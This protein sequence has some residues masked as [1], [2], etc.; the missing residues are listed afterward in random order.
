MIPTDLKSDPDVDK[1][2]TAVKKLNPEIKTDDR[3]D[4]YYYVTGVSGANYRINWSTNRPSALL[5]RGSLNFNWLHLS[6]VAPGYVNTG[7]EYLASLL[8]SLRND[9][10]C[11]VYIPTLRS[12]IQEYADLS[13]TNPCN[14]TDK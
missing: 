10:A 1:L 14:L 12:V 5:H 4:T 11:A 9:L 7:A 8:Y 3:G 2:I 6:I 13:D